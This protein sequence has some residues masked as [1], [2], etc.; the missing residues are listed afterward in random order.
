MNMRITAISIILI[1]MLASCGPVT[2]IPSSSMVEVATGTSSQV[3]LSA[4][5]KKP[6]STITPLPTIPTFTPTFDVSIL[7]TVT[8]SQPE[9]CPQIDPSIEP[10]LG[11]PTKFDIN[12][13]FVPGL[14]ENAIDFLNRGGDY[15]KLVSEIRR[16][17]TM[18]GSDPPFPLVQD[19]TGD[20]VPEIAIRDENIFS[21]IHIFSCVQGRYSDFIPLATDTTGGWP[22]HLYAIEDLNADNLPEVLLKSANWMGIYEWDGKDF[23]I[24]NPGM[25][26]IGGAEYEFRDIDNNGTKEMLLKHTAPVDQVLGFPWRSYTTIYMWNGEIFSVQ[27]EVF[28]TPIYRFQAVQD[29]DREAENGRYPQALFLYQNVIS[30]KS[31]EWWS[32]ARYQYELSNLISTQPSIL[33]TPTPDLTEYPRLASYAYYRILL[34]YIVQGQESEARTSYQALQEKFSV[35]PYGHPYAEI[36]TA[37][38]EAYQ[39]DHSITTACGAAIEYVT[40]H[41]DILVPLGSD[42]HGLQSHNYKPEDVC[43]FR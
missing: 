25:G 31:L 43:P 26:V 13:P 17:Y 33:P 32:R 6:T 7:V 40:I 16:Y 21:T 27:S 20:N 39:S 41:P 38:W 18:L 14:A 28:A 4:P 1:A 35:D 34:I 9:T 24:L 30:G 22:T 2:S 23:R 19:L 15:R 37:F 10:N 42:Y 12:N 8:P 36:A 3:P 5:T 11:L 29:A